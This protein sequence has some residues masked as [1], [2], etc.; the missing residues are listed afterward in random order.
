[1]IQLHTVPVHA[2]L[3][4]W[5]GYR[6]RSNEPSW[7]TRVDDRANFSVIEISHIHPLHELFVIRLQKIGFYRALLLEGKSMTP[8]WVTYLR[9]LNRGQN[10]CTRSRIRMIRI[11]AC[12]NDRRVHQRPFVR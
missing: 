4:L 12:W 9:K 6:V 2:V 8:S 3:I 1:M 7:V 10:R 5:Y 11:H